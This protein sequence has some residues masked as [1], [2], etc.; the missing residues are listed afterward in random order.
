MINRRIGALLFMSWIL[1]PGTTQAQSSGVL[2]HDTGYT[3]TKVRIASKRGDSYII[4]SSYEGIVLGMGYDGTVLWKNP[5]SG[6]MNHDLWCGDVTRDGADEVFAANA[7]GTVYCL[8]TMGQLLWQFKANDAP[9]NAVCVVHDEAESTVVCG[10]YD[11]RI[12]YL[13][14]QGRLIK[15]IPS[16]TYSKDKTWGKNPSKPSPPSGTHIANHLRRIPQPDGRDILVVQGANNSHAG[17]G[18]IYLFK[19]LEDRPFKTLQIEKGNAVG[20][21]RICDVNGDGI[22]EILLGATSMIDRA[23]VIRMDVSDG[24]QTEFK[25]S[26]LRKQIDGFGYRVV[27][28]ELISQGSSGLYFVL[29]G[30]RVLLVPLNMDSRNTEI[31][32]CRYSFNDMWQDTTKGKIILASSQSGGSCIHVLD[33]KDSAWKEAYTNLTPPGKISTILKNTEQVRRHLESFTQPVWERDPL[34]VY[35]MGERI[36][37][38]IENRINRIKNTSKSPIFLNGFHMPRAENWDRST[39]QNQRYRDKRD[40]RKKYS[41]TQTQALDVILPKYEG[42]PG[43][44]FWA[45]HGNDPYM[46]SL[47][48]LKKVLNGSNGKKTVLI[49]P[50]LEDHGDDFEFVMD[51]LIYPLARYAQAKNGKL[52]IR[53]KHAFWQGSV[54]LPTWSRLVSGEF[55]DVFVP[56]M[57]ETTDKTMEQSLAGRT[58][59]WASGAVDSWGTRAARDNPSFNRL[60]QHSHQMLPNHFLRTMVYHVS[61]GAQYLD[62]FPVDQRY[63]SL[64]WELIAE[65]AVYVP[66]RSEI[67]SFSPI[68]LSMAKPDE[69]YLNEG[70][71]VKWVTFFDKEAEKK[72]PLVFGRLNGTWPGAP[73][74]PWDFSRYAAGVKERRLN[75]LPSYENGLVL[76]TPPQQGPFAAKN[77][78]RGALIDHLHPLY[79][80][81]MTEYITDGRHYYSANGTQRYAAD[82]YYKT[83][84]SDIKHGASLLPLTV[85]G[86]VAWVTAQT[87]PTHLRLTL[88]DSGYINPKERTATVS[89]HSVRPAQMVDLLDKQGFDITDPLGVKID[90]PCGMFRFI[91]IEL[92]APLTAAPGGEKKFHE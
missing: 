16:K 71:N 8:N 28:T 79:K 67:V 14:A 27:Q 39:I 90:I 84:E 47:D 61:L 63:M 1:V 91:D 87:S 89:F 25:I 80:H 34:P 58:G 23:S 32:T 12:Y 55:A 3:I 15:E 52:Y 64:L 75:F 13:S 42:T 82:T 69:Y 17:R 26:S 65:G 62:N 38:S 45:G 53:T 24:S 54:Y 44:S 41:L 51:D 37:K 9:M 68:H 35:L 19:P 72:N 36:P 59:L 88:I 31:L 30:S 56:A 43:I 48:T 5:L 60:R 22:S 85:S 29:F 33:L 92:T 76:V 11:K 46:F 21:L 86:D 77:P 83:I 57:E 2:S 49:Y 7:D 73:V 18:T 70:S 20:D 40:Q 4:A 81:I 50:E 74:T 10:G 78:P 6:F 66:K